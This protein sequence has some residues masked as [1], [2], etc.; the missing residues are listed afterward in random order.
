MTARTRAVMLLSGW[1]WV[2]VARAEAPDG[3]ALQQ[4]ELVELH[5][6]LAAA[7][8]DRRDAALNELIS[9]GD[10]DLPAVRTRLRELAHDKSDHSAWLAKLPVLTQTRAIDPK[11][12]REDR[13]VGLR[14]ALERDRS[15]AMVRVV[16]L[17]A[18][19][20]ALEAQHTILAADV[21]V[22]ELFAIEP[23][24]FRT[25]FAATRRTL[26]KLLVPAYLRARSQAPVLVQKSARDGLAALGA[27]SDEAEY[28]QRNAELLA[29]S[30]AVDSDLG[31]SEALP[32]IVGLLDDT[33]PAVRAAAR[34]AIAA[35]TQESM[36][37][38]RQRMADL[39]GEEPDPRLDA[40]QLLD[41][42]E[43]QIDSAREQPAVQA[44]QRAETMLAG[45]EL[46]AAEHTLDGALE[47]AASPNKRALLAARY[48]A[49]ATKYDERDLPERALVTARRAQRLALP[50]S[51]DERRARAHVLYLEAE[52]RAGQGIADLASLQASAELEPTRL[53][54]QDLLQELR[55][56]RI[57]GDHALRK[58]LGLVAAVLL[59]LSALLM[60]YLR[61]QA[62]KLRTR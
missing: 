53:A 24:L 20:T 21:L 16:E 59:T 49:L 50:G 32:W 34:K 42:L 22:N 30:I 26:G 5:A 47:H 9:L 11:G 39:A 2:Q 3:L 54:A 31:R 12:T 37:L 57:D 35:H 29:A 25:Q 33:R 60:L 4:R 1:A 40:A 10:Q 36:D 62:R 45:N 28:A 58:R 56:L 52:R 43:R 48:L 61:A 51:S 27:A 6:Q 13:T 55:G 7:S 14:E 8:A 41:R 17:F 15:S 44:L 18:L 46:E 23:R 19:V 38:L